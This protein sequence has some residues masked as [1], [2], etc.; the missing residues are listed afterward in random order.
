MEIQHTNGA[1]DRVDQKVD[2]VSVPMLNLSMEGKLL[3]RV[4][5]LAANSTL[6]V[7]EQRRGYR[8]E[9][10]GDIIISK[11]RSRV[12]TKRAHEGRGRRGDSMKR[13]RDTGTKRIAK[14]K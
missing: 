5:S 9:R 7:E 14:L 12:L 8:R 2:R 4:K 11:A 10:H 13:T 6:G 3:E 1:R